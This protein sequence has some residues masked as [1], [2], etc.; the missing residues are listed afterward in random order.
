M[1]RPLPSNLTIKNS[2]IDGLGLFS[3]E[4][5]PAETDL[6]M[7]HI[8]DD[9]FPDNYIRLPLGGFFNHST[10]PNCEIVDSIDNGIKHLRL[11]TIVE[12]YTYLTSTG[13]H[14]KTN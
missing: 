14:D 12:E 9:R 2:N 5:I 10:N 11:K 3:T 6:G 8:Y 1:Y 4:F 7:T 13:L